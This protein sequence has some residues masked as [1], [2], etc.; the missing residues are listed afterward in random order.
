MAADPWRP[1]VRWGAVAAIVVLAMI[2]LQAVVFLLSPP[3]TTVADYFALFQANP[4]LGLLDL[5]LLLTLDYVVMIPF[6]LALFVLLRRREPSLALLALTLGLFSLAL[7]FVSREATFSMWQLS[8]QYVAADE[9]GRAAAL[10]SGQTLLTLYN[11]GTF[12]L[13]YLLGAASTL[14][15]SLAM[16]RTLL[17][18]RAAAVVGLVT[19]ATMLVPPNT[20]GVGLVVSMLS[21]IPTAVWL[22]LLARGMLRK[23]Q[24]T[25]P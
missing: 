3:P 24:L 12:G 4:L 19:G 10:A 15:F 11:G 8:T 14:L 16:L 9:P 5:D 7:F 2:P 13:S 1:L 20:G 25:S 17:F 18:G 21:L 23:T 22:V 6:Y